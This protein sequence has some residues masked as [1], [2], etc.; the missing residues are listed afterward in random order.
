M[1]SEPG[2]SGTGRPEAT[3]IIPTSGRWTALDTTL[4]ALAEVPDAPSWELIVVENAAGST[5]LPSIVER[6]E[7]RPR[8]R[9]LRIAEA[10][11]N[12][13]RNRGARESRGEVLIFLDDDIVAPRD[14]VSAR[15]ALLRGQPGRWV[16]GPVV[17][18]LATSS[19]TPFDRY[20]AGVT[21]EWTA[22]QGS[23][24][25]PTRF[26]C[27]GNFAARRDELLRIGGFL[28]SMPQGGQD[29]ELRIRAHRD[30]GIEVLF[31]PDLEVTHVEPRTGCERY[32][33]RETERSKT[34]VLLWNWY[35]SETGLADRVLAN[36]PLRR[37][38]RR[39]GRLASA[40]AKRAL[41]TPAGSALL[42]A[43]IR[44]LERGGDLTPMLA[45][46]YRTAEGVA[47]HRGVREGIRLHGLAPL[48]PPS[49][50]PI[51]PSS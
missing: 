23:V 41:A 1:A 51:D 29:T 21:A 49:A 10:G 18:R 13:A 39:P 6:F 20:R 8:W 35:G 19:R 47:I 31:D 3:V 11:A 5:P 27:A 17:D 42:G 44:T 16:T 30:A 25:G 34:H 24:R 38:W 36:G 40:L 14:L 26:L 48:P 50:D 32:L 4:S 12:P 9:L 15:V 37:L 33:Q 7:E 28:S 45:K 22:L 2:P 46:L 43:C